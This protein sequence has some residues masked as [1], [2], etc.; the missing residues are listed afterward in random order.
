MPFFCIRYTTIIIIRRRRS[1]SRSSPVEQ[2]QCSVPIQFLFVTKHSSDRILRLTRRLPLSD[3]NDNIVRGLLHPS[4]SFS[5]LRS[6][7]SA[8]KQSAALLR[9]KIVDSVHNAKEIHEMSF[10]SNI[11][12]AH[13]NQPTHPSKLHYEELYIEFIGPCSLP[14]RTMHVQHNMYIQTLCN[15]CVLSL[16]SG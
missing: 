13:G 16:C 5:I 7:A 10:K 6:P 14:I 2:Q 8:T 1:T 3:N 4:L 15:M 9:L 12:R 11:A